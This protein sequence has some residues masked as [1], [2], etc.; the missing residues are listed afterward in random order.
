MIRMLRVLSIKDVQF[1]QNAAH[2]HFELISD[3]FVML[4]MV[5]SEQI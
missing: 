1:S 2:V 5:A 4:I 3:M